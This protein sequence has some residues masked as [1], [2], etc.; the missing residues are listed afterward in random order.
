MPSSFT[1]QEDY[2]L[3]MAVW[4]INK[5]NDL[6][7]KGEI[8]G[9]RKREGLKILEKMDSCLLNIRESNFSKQQLLRS[10]AFGGFSDL[11]STFMSKLGRNWFRIAK[12]KDEFTAKLLRFSIFNLRSLG[13]RLKKARNEI[14]ANAVRIRFARILDVKDLSSS[15]SKIHGVNA[16]DMDI[17][18]EITVQDNDVTPGDILLFSHLPPKRVHGWI[19]EG[20][21]LKKDDDLIKGKGEDI[22][23]RPS[24]IPKKA[25]RETNKR[26]RDLLEEAF[27]I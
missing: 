17:K 19:S 4:A 20:I 15:D 27:L 8:P 14:P 9:I 5:L 21:P 7:K 23:K 6:E 11:L 10:S 16:T 18:Y 3:A 22:G 2:R 25:L 12:M 24:N 1:P 26:V 13:M